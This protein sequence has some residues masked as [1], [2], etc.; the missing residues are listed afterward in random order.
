[1]IGFSIVFPILMLLPSREKGALFIIFVVITAVI[2]L[3]I[4]K[5]I[6]DLIKDLKKYDVDGVEK[7]EYAIIKSKHTRTNRFE[8]DEPERILE[9][10][11]DVETESG[12]IIE[13]LKCSSKVFDKNYEGDKVLVIVIDH[14]FIDV[15]SLN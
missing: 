3:P 4:I 11:V 6:I 1:M 13:N 7:S 15:I 8:Y 5:A 12:E 9:H 10:F 2:E 14:I